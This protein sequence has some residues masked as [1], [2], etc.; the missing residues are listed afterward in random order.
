MAWERSD[1]FKASV[2][3]ED[4]SK[5]IIDTCPE[6]MRNGGLKYYDDKK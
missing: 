2:M 6:C 1:I 4:S 3:N 5:Y